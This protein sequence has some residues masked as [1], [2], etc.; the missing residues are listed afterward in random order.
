MLIVGGAVLAIIM[1]P[2]VTTAAENFKDVFVVNDADH[3]VPTLAQGTTQ[4][5]GTVDVA[6]GAADHEPYQHTQVFNQTDATCEPLGCNVVFP[7]VPAG[8]RLVLTYASAA[9]SLAPGGLAPNVTVSNGTGDRIYL[10][11]PAGTDFGGVLV[12]GPVT[13]YIEAGNQPTMRL[14]GQFVL[15]V[16][17]TAQAALVGYL[18]PAV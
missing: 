1:M 18:V 13:F 2:Q 14:A 3:P 6:K 10:P 4:V 5:A 7:A 8:K 12:S 17:R 16:S 15:P 11:L 9:Y